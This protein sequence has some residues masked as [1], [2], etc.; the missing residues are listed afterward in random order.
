M[1]SLIPSNSSVLIKSPRLPEDTYGSVRYVGGVQG[2]AAQWVGVELEQPLGT[3]DGTANVNGKRYFE[4]KP[5]Y[6]LFVRPWLVEVLEKENASGVAETFEKITATELSAYIL[7]KCRDLKFLD[8]VAASVK[9]RQKELKARRDRKGGNRALRDNIKTKQLFARVRALQDAFVKSEKEYFEN[10]SRVHGLYIKGFR[11]D[12]I[13]TNE[14]AEELFAN[15]DT[16]KELSQHMLEEITAETESTGFVLERYAP[17]FQMYR[18]YIENL[19]EVALPKLRALESG[20]SQES[21]AFQDYCNNIIATG[22]TRGLELASL[23]AMPVER[24]PCYVQLARDLLKEYKKIPSTAKGAYSEMEAL[25]NSSRRIASVAIV[26]GLASPSKLIRSFSSTVPKSPKTSLTPGRAVSS[27]PRVKQTGSTTK[28]AMRDA[29]LCPQKRGGKRSPKA[30]RP[31]PASP[32]RSREGSNGALG[33]SSSSLF[34]MKG[35]KSA[36]NTLQ[37]DRKGNEVLL[38]GTPHYVDVYH[39]SADPAAAVRGKRGTSKVGNKQN[40]SG[41]KYETAA[42]FLDRTS[43]KKGK[44]GSTRKGAF[45]KLAKNPDSLILKAYGNDM[46]D[47]AVRKGGKQARPMPKSHK[48]KVKAKSKGQKRG[49]QKYQ[50]RMNHAKTLEE[51]KRKQNVKL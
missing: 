1:A 12:G 34:T 35:P 2:T 51:V 37:I 19:N 48:R 8:Q 18:V 25:A 13:V 38:K 47:S 43:R 31:K 24:L 39:S 5:K 42:E 11:N 36:T 6:G 7:T 28:K 50:E 15:F 17:Y 14:V 21:A 33:L 41:K 45:K 30:K 22:A 46:I 23:L 29:P 10:L 49:L 26:S 32:N 44:R 9:S 3:N 27:G 16:I 4:C 20:A 40:L